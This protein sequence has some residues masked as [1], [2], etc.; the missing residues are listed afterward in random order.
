MGGYPFPPYF[1]GKVFEKLGLG[2]YRYG[3]FQG[4]PDTSGLAWPLIPLWARQDERQGCGSRVKRSVATWVRQL[5]HDRA[6][7]EFLRE[8]HDGSETRYSSLAAL[9]PEIRSGLGFSAVGH[10]IT[11]GAG[12]GEMADVEDYLPHVFVGELALGGWHA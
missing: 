12:G 8:C 10:G 9:L 4:G 5:R 11:E 3:Y 1:C 7:A 6:T 2:R